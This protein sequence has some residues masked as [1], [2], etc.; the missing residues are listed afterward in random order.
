MSSLSGKHLFIIGIRLGGG[1]TGLLELGLIGGFRAGSLIFSHLGN[2]ASW[3]VGRSCMKRPGIKRGP[4]GSFARFGRAA[5]GR[6]GC[7]T[8]GVD[9]GC[10]VGRYLRRYEETGG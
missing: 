2:A 8:G 5:T 7:A 3:V 4:Y 1:G 9:T 6:S 10:L